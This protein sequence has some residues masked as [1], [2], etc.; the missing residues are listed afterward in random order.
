MAIYKSDIV[1]V[2]L[3][4]G[5][6]DRSFLKHSI[7]SGDNDANRFGVRTFRGGVPAD[8]TGV[9]I[10]GIFMNAAG[11]NIALTSYGTVDG[12]VAYVTLPQACYN[13][14]GQF[15]LALK[16]VQ[17][18][19]TVTGRIVDGMV[20]NTGTVGT[21]APTASVPTYQEI[22]AQFDA[23]V[24]ATAAAEAAA[25]NPAVATAFD[26]TQEYSAGQYVLYNALLY[27]L[28][29]D[30]AANVSWSNTI[31]TQVTMANEVAVVN[32][33]LDGSL[34]PLIRKYGT[35][36]GVTIQLRGK[37]VPY[38]YKEGERVN[39][40]SS[41]RFTLPDNVKTVDISM[42]GLQNMNS[43]TFLDEN[44]NVLYYKYETSN[45]N[46]SYEGLNA[47]EARYL[48]CSNNNTYIG[49]IRVTATVGGVGPYIDEA[50]KANG[51]QWT[52]LH[53]VPQP[54]YYSDTT[55]GEANY[56]AEFD[57]AGYDFVEVTS[58]NISGV[59]KYTFLDSNGD[60]IGYFRTADQSE[61]Q[62]VTTVKVAVPANAAK[63]W[64]GTYRV[65]RPNVIVYGIT[66]PDDFG[67]V[68]C[69]G[70]FVDYMYT[71]SNYNERENGSKEYTA[72][73]YDMFKIVNG[74]ATNNINAFTAF[75][76]DGNVIGYVSLRSQDVT[77]ETYYICP[78][79]TVKIAIASGRAGTGWSTSASIQVMKRKTTKLMSVLGDS[80]TTFENFV[81]SSEYNPFYMVGNHD[82]HSAAETWWGRVLIE[83]GWKLSTDNAWGGSQVAARGTDY[84]ASAMC[85]TRCQDLARGGTPDVIIILGGTNDFGHGVPVGTWGGDADLPEEDNNFRA[86]YANMLMK[87]HA[88]YPLAKVY[89]CS[90]INRETD[91]VPGSM[92]KKHGQ[93]L[94][95]F[96]TAIRQIAPMI[97]CTLIDLESCGLN[98]YNMSTYMADY[99]PTDHHAVHPNS[100]GMRLMAE[101]ILNSLI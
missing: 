93:Y 13:V 1:D 5:N 12:N 69:A 46:V 61:I 88:Q 43:Y 79:G 45:G 28:N 42:Y 18:G 44:D 90:L 95:A 67:W 17:S 80:I 29:A 74:M 31:K 86:A 49:T 2:E 65:Q 82:V 59:N 14:E 84:T 35:T 47:W 77:D 76:A 66:E 96:N 26:V 27:K 60:V 94:T 98:Q 85:R 34:E 92:E 10:Q 4:N 9:S 62:T 101:R 81:P 63:V 48:V 57:I 68:N 87:I 38:R 7:G 70:T 15:T 100:E 91:L 24:A 8:L 3:E 41:M 75:D 37:T 30:H 56:T 21:V 83:K 36:D 40:Q 99:D 11:V 23:M 73:Q 19:V 39:T 78:T 72:S 33:Q 6:I 54:Y 32:E 22:I 25:N 58:Y 51:E 53:G 50:K 52:L 20:D 16:L 55:V 89:C 97:N 71:G 64:V